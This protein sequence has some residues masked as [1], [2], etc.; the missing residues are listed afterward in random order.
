MPKLKDTQLVILS[1]AAQRDGGGALPLPKSLKIKG[2]ALAKTLDQLRKQGL[3]EEK[4][5]PHGAAAWREGEDGGR[6]MLVITPAGVKALESEITSATPHSKSVKS[7]A[8][9]QRN[10]RAAVHAKH[11]RR[12]AAPTPRVGTKQDVLISLLQRK[13]GATI[14]DV[15]A[16]TGWQAHSVRGAIS[17][18]LK[19]KLG[20]AIS[21]EKAERGRIYRIAG[22]A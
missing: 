20:L 21:S 1:A 7:Q 5:A 8:T 22:R 13:S 2:A 19:K 18:V 11:E 16:A 17:G 12:T 9:K 4:P 15:V 3:L 6:M 10:T 14:D